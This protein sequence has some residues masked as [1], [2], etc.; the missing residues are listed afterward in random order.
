MSGRLR[1]PMVVAGI[2][3]LSGLAATL[4]QP[5]QA[6][7]QTFVPTSPTLAATTT[8]ELATTT[9]AR[10]PMELECPSFERSPGSYRAEFE[11][12]LPVDA[13][14][15]SATLDYG[16][17][18]SYTSPTEEDAARNLFWHVYDDPSTYRVTLDFEDAEGRSFSA[19]CEFGWARP[20]TTSTPPTTPPPTTTPPTT[21]VTVPPTTGAPLNQCDPNYSGC[22]PIASDVDCA[23]GS[24]NGPAYV[25][26]PVNVIGR[27]IYDLDRDNDG[28]GCE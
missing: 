21:R 18:H 10:P 28:V 25:R 11:A 6:E 19:M 27:D 1:V 14:W 3:G 13:E 23:G 2:V 22:V 7:V 5:E 9:T 16:D 20:R 4:D 26:G 17:G 8:T 24:G 12:R 15:G